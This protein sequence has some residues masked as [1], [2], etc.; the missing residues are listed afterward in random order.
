MAKDVKV[1]KPKPGIPSEW[2]EEGKCK[3]IDSRLF[4]SEIQS[5][6]REALNACM[7]CCVKDQCRDYAITN[8]EHGVWGGTTE[9]QRRAILRRMRFER[10]SSSNDLTAT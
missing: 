3:S 8:Q 1:A 2:K 9:R 6:I 10:K 4:F 7:N 5:Q